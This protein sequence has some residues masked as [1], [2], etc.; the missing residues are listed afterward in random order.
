MKVAP[1]NIT[2][3]GDGLE[4]NYDTLSV[5][6][7]K[8]VKTSLL[9]RQFKFP[10]EQKFKDKVLEVFNVDIYEYKNKNVVLRP[11]MF[12]EIAIK[13]NKFILIEDPETDDNKEAINDDLE[14][15]YNSYVFYGDKNAL[16]W[17][18]LNNK[19]EL[20][21][22]VI[23]YGY[24]SDFELLKFVLEKFDFDNESS[25]EK[26]IFDQ[27]EKLEIREDILE[28]ILLV[29]YGGKSKDLSYA[30]EGNGFS[31]IGHIVGNIR[32]NP[33]L[34]SNPNKTIAILLNKD[35]EVGV[36]GNTEAILIKNPDYK[37]YL[38]KNKYFNFQRLRDYVELLYG[39]NPNS[40]NESIYKI[41]DPN[42]YTN[43]RKDKSSTSDIVEKVKSGDRIEVLDNS[44]NWWY[45][46]TKSGNKGYV[47][48]T[49]I[50]N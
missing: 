46:Q 28:G 25:F 30:K 38:K 48:K 37:S 43:L 32:N 23:E 7:I 19:E 16:N 8:K 27:N 20:K 39:Q 17:L 36:V 44:G 47:Y 26:L 40:E 13:E 3:L 35:L 9:N 4:Y 22:L 50:A 41:N 1:Y 18:K 15:Y 34:Y 29:N 14:F 24:V 10:D 45:V 2:D 33:N 5:N 11:A 21:D 12:T 31:E 49:K 42:G 6:Y